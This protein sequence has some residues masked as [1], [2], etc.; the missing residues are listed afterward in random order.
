MAEA[1]IAKRSLFAI[2]FVMSEEAQE[3]FKNN[4]ARLQ[5]ALKAGAVHWHKNILNH[6][7]EKPAHDKYGYARRSAAYLNQPKK[8]NKP[9]LV[10]SGMLRR[11]VLSGF[12][13]VV[14]TKSVG[15]KMYGRALNFVS[16]EN[17]PDYYVL[18]YDRHKKQNR[19]Y[20]NMKRE[21]RLTTEEERTEINGVIEN[22]LQDSYTAQHTLEGVAHVIPAT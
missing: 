16:K 10:Y 3:I 8:K 9:D 5:A 7:F 21:I 14:G 4:P 18:M 19:S 22:A 1:A 13:F 12:S 17:S 6:H 15:V 20:P 2:Q 11:Q